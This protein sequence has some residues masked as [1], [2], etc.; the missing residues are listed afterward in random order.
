R[1]EVKIAVLTSLG[2]RSDGA[3]CRALEIDAYLT[4]PI[5]SDHLREAIKTMLAKAP[6]LSGKTTNNLITRHSVGASARVPLR[7]LVAEDNRV[8]QM[9]AR[10][11]LE[12]HGHYVFVAEN[13]REAVDAVISR[14]FDVVLM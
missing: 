9:L 2:L 4:K 10:R 3:R 1:S 12:K 14:Q 6:K 11:I 13:G 7:I 5:E 8:N